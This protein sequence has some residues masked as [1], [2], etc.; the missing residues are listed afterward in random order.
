MRLVQI[1]QDVFI[2]PESVHAVYRDKEYGVIRIA[3]ANGVSY[4]SDKYYSEGLKVITDRLQICEEN[5]PTS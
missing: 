3:M 5:I 2:N 1:S 4:E